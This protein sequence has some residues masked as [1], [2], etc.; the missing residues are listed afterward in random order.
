MIWVIMRVKFTWQ[1][2]QKNKGKSG[3][4]RVITL[5]VVVDITN[6]DIYLITIYDKGEQDSITR[7]EIEQ[8]KRVNGL[9]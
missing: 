4:A 8:L 3:G 9:I 2:P 7:K 6:T 5:D 1:L